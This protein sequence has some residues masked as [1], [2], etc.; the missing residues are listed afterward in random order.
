MNL[1]TPILQNQGS[2]YVQNRHSATNSSRTASAA[3]ETSC[4]LS[5]CEKVH[6]Y[7]TR[8]SSLTSVINMYHRMPPTLRHVQFGSLDPPPRYY[9][10]TEDFEFKQPFVTTTIEPIAPT[11]TRIPS[12]HKSLVFREGSEDQLSVQHVEIEENGDQSD[13]TQSHQSRVAQDLSEGDTTSI[14]NTISKSPITKWRGTDIDCLPSQTGRDLMD[15]F[16]R[17]PEIELREAGICSYHDLRLTAASGAKTTSLEKQVV[18]HG[19]KTPT[20]RSEQGFIMRGDSHDSKSEKCEQKDGIHFGSKENTFQ[21]RSAS[22]PSTEYCGFFPNHSVSEQGWISFPTDSCVSM[23]EAYRTQEPRELLSSSDS[24]GDYRGTGLDRIIGGSIGSASFMTA[25]TIPENTGGKSAMDQSEHQ[26]KSAQNNTATV[27]VKGGSVGCQGEHTFYGGNTGLKIVTRNLQ[28]S[29]D[30]DFPQ[31][32]PECSKTPLVSPKPIS[33]ARQLKV[34]NSIPQLMKALPPLPTKSL[35]SSTPS[36]TV[37]SYE[38]A[39]ILQPFS[40]SRSGTPRPQSQ[41][42]LRQPRDRFDLRYAGEANDTQKKLPKIRLKTKLPATHE[43]NQRDSRPWSSES[44][45]PWCR[46]TNDAELLST[47]GDAGSHYSEKGSLRTPTYLSTHGATSSPL[48]ET[49]RRYSHVQHSGA[50]QSFAGQQPRD[51]F[52]ASSRLCDVFR[53]AS[54]GDVQA[55]NHTKKGLDAQC[56]LVASKKATPEADPTCMTA[57]SSDSRRLRKAQSHISISGKPREA[58]S[59]QHMRKERTRGLR[60]RLP[61]L[62]MLLARNRRP[63]SEPLGMLLDSNPTSGVDQHVFMEA[64]PCLGNV[65][66]ESRSF[67][68][69]EGIPGETPRRRKFRRRVKDRISKWVKVIRIRMGAHGCREEA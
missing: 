14:A 39:E 67:T 53:L 17:S 44:N 51:L 21:K 62:R 9:D 47:N 55:D 64:S 13:E 24:L 58:V 49:V 7:S 16:N 63:Q 3:S 54:S 28:N 37:D 50:I 52:T 34:K 4:S 8:T 18:F 19:G 69:S 32:T 11:P 36:S 65:D 1:S 56:S 23:S 6:S 22:E 20:I 66:F 30:D 10:Y 27:G 33:P 29:S 68:V 46:E 45:Y 31:L 48:T 42:G 61:N 60:K 40:L 25:E 35:A 41:R 12:I 57:H 15:T 26:L 2:H 38:C 43:T 5:C 59:S